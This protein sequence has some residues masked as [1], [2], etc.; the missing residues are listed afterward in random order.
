[1]NSNKKQKKKNETEW[2]PSTKATS[3][4]IDYSG[5]NIVGGIIGV[6]SKIN[7]N[8][9]VSNNIVEGYEDPAKLFGEKGNLIMGTVAMHGTELN[10]P[11]GI[12]IKN[13]VSK[14]GR[15]SLSANVVFIVKCK[16]MNLN[17]AM[18][19]ENAP[20]FADHFS[21][22]NKYTID[23][24]KPE[25]FQAML[26]FIETGNVDVKFLDINSKALLKACHDVSI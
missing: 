19:E 11:N 4:H 6:G 10:T 15:I 1:M 12:H 2:K 3:S 22:E 7:A 5:K 17:R 18:M 9:I 8:E 20:N 24:V 26:D 16:S 13:R 23:D 14:K 25:V 21:D